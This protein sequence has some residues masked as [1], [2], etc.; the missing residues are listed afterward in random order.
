MKTCIAGYYLMLAFLL[1]MHPLAAQNV[2][3]GTTAP[4]TTLDV[5][6]KVTFSRD[7]Q[8]ECCGNDATLALAEST[9]GTGQVASTA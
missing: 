2:G 4:S 6:G 8:T 5:H 7:G 9:S 1:G 3:I